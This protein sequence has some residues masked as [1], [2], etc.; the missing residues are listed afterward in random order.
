MGEPRPAFTVAQKFTLKEL[1]WQACKKD[2]KKYQRFWGRL[3]AKE[4]LS[5]V[6]SS[7]LIRWTPSGE[8]LTED[9]FWSMFNNYE[10][11]LHNYATV[12]GIA[13]SWFECF[14]YLNNDGHKVVINSFGVDT[15]KV[16]TRTV[17][18]EHKTVQI[19]INYE[20]WGERDMKEFNVLHM[21]KC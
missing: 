19:A 1:V 4:F 16:V 14:R 2:N 11:E 15:R 17:Y 5:L 20:M 6:L 3:N 10:T 12:D 18:D 7:S 21:A 9:H 8:V 13:M